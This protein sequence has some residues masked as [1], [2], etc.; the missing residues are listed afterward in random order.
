[1]N[2]EKMRLGDFGRDFE[3]LIVERDNEWESNVCYLKLKLNIGLNAVL[4]PYFDWI[5]ILP[6]L[7]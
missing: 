1:M 5:W 4:P 3:R 2:F 7:F 6:P